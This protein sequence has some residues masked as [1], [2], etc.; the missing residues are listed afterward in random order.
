MALSQSEEVTQKKHGCL[1]LKTLSGIGA[2]FENFCL[3]VAAIT[4][5]QEGYMLEHISICRFWVIA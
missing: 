5:R 4:W 2:E 3:Q 1:S